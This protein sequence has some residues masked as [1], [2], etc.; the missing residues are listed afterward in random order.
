MCS[1]FNVIG[2]IEKY[3]K[4]FLEQLYNQ[5]LDVNVVIRKQGGVFQKVSFVISFLLTV[6]RVKPQFIFCGHLNF[7]P[8]CLIVYLLLKVPFS[9]ALYGIEI[10]KISRGIFKIS[11]QKAQLL[12]TISGFSRSLI[13]SHSAEQGDKIF[14]LPSSVDGDKFYPKPKSGALIDKYSLRGKKVVLSLAR[15]SSDEHKG[16]DRVLKAWSKVLEVF[17][18]AVYLIVGSDSMIGC[19]KS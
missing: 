7:A 19:K 11:V 2:G 12:I 15:L 8:L 3:N 1:D 14:M 13:K 4:D 18:D 5:K 9:I 6:L 10:P 17:P 16:Q